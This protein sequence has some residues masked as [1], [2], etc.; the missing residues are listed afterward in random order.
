MP[1]NNTYQR[2]DLPAAFQ[3]SGQTYELQPG[4]PVIISQNEIISAGQQVNGHT[5]YYQQGVGSGQPG[6]I[7]YF[8]LPGSS[9]I[10]V[11]YLPSG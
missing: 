4:A 7:I 11:Q 5:I 2:T 3:W 1:P 6:D 9:N 8:K 10:Y